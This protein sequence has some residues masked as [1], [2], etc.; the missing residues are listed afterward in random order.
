M[1]KVTK[2]ASFQSYKDRRPPWI[3]LHKS[4]LDNFEFQTMS[5][6]AK[7][8]LP[9]LWL[10]ASED[11]D[12]VSGCIRDRYEKVAFRLRIDTS[13]LQKVID[14]CVAAGFIE[15]LDDETGQPITLPLQEVTEPIHNRY[16]TVTPE[17]RDRDRDREQRQRTEAET[18]SC[19]EPSAPTRA[20]ATRKQAPQREAKSAATWNAYADVYRQRYGV[21]PV[22]NAKV[23]A[24][25][26]QVV[27]RLGA[28][29]A[30]QVAA[31]YVRHNAQWYVTKGHCVDALLADCEKL[32][33]EWATGRRITQTGAKQADRKANNADIAAQ[34]IAE[35]RAKE[36]THGK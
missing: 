20:L 13:T 10:L 21:E 25:L 8:I 9:M 1:L 14:E 12:P 11:E 27:S 24:Q 3:R 28:E 4:L 19:A 22:R 31:F 18:D 29:D 35:M 5:M 33:T 30:P 36:G 2:W 6:E 23:N 15:V 7:A 16:E 26:A 17:Y 32:R 34:L